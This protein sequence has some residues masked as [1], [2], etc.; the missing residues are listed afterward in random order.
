MTDETESGN[1]LAAFLL[2]PW[3]K[4]GPKPTGKPYERKRTRRKSLPCPKCNFPVSRQY[5]IKGQG[6]EEPYLWRRRRCLECDH[7]FTTYERIEIHAEMIVMKTDGKREPFDRE[8]LVKS[9]R[10]A[11]AKRNVTDER[12]WRIAKS[13]EV[14]L[15]KRGKT[16]LSQATEAQVLD[17]PS[18]R[19]GNLVLASLK[20]LDHVA[21][22]RY[23]SVFLRFHD[24]EAFVTLADSLSV[25]E[26]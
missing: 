14:E 25:N 26:T 9:L 11:F 24:K 5:T 23:A 20:E 12:M 19:I 22:L 13:I 1:D 21:F 10:L 7:R 8:K 18:Q 17:I 4:A 3:K 15:A 2:A 16:V 6:L